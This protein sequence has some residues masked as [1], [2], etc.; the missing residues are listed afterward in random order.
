MGVL[1]LACIALGV[2]NRHFALIS[3]RTLTLTARPTY[4]ACVVS[5]PPPF[6]GACIY[7]L[8]VCDAF[9]NCVG[10]WLSHTAA[11]ISLTSHLPLHTAEPAL[12]QE[13]L[14][15]LTVV[16]ESSSAFLTILRCVMA[17]RAGGGVEKLRDG[18]I[19]ILFK[20]GFGAS[21][22]RCTPGC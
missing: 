9:I 17:I 8:L 6:I 5:G 16:F 15:I 2:V 4:Q 21:F 19:F 10:F 22:L 11:S 13:T 14:S 12:A 1:G 18:V 3:I 7:V 20:Q